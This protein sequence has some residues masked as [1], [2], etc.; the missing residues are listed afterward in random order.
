MYILAWNDGIIRAF[1]PQ[2]GQLIFAI[3]NAHVK[4]VSAVCITM[5]GTKL[6]SGGCDGQVSL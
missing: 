4:A 5:D 6:I 1:T 3:H 2:S